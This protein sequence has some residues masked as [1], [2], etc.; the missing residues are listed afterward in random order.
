MFQYIKQ[1]ARHCFPNFYQR[2]HDHKCNCWIRGDD[3]N[4][5]QKLIGNSQ[6]LVET[7]IDQ[8]IP[9][10]PAP[11]LPD[12]FMDGLGR[13]LSGYEILLRSPFSYALMP[14]D[15]VDSSVGLN[16]SL[17]VMLVVSALRIDP[18]V[19]RE[20]RALAEGGYRVHVIAPDISHPPLKEEPID[21]GDRVS[22]EILDSSAADFCMADPYLHGEMMLAA[23]VRYRPLV[24]H[25]HDLSTCL[26]GLAAAR[27]CGSK[28]VCDFH[29][30]FSENVSWSIPQEQW[31]P[32]PQSK[33]DLF[34]AAESLVM[35]QSDEVIT[36]CESIAKELDAKFPWRRR[37]VS[38]IR[39]IPNLSLTPTQDYPSIKE[40]IGV[41]DDAFVV[42]YQGGIGPTRMIEPII[43]A[44]EFSMDTILVVRGPSLDLFGETY[45]KTAV[46]RGVGNR[47]LL[48]PPVPSRDVVIA[49]KGADAGIYTVA[50]LCKNFY[51]AL[52][53]KI[54]EYVGAELPVLAANY[55]E[56]ESL[57]SRYEIGLT[58][59]PVSP[60]SI[61]EVFEK[62][63]DGEVR[64]AFRRNVIAYKEELIATK[65]MDKLV[66]L[67]DG[68]RD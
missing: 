3:T 8:T 26:I 12:N 37:N 62:M 2:L 56:V 27:Y 28:V 65:E 7:S 19:E 60:L 24:F 25:C 32:H 23:A 22:F 53:N 64:G 15:K 58:F 20:A 43:Q 35:R 17:I 51:Y 34:L 40:Q 59:D 10:H 55:P 48:L 18:R 68:L 61:A 5:T 16:D 57:V 47:L 36:V 39:N 49:A 30:W 1:I 41:D 6:E 44:L 45:K 11:T 9:S 66:S 67:Y 13:T 31:V 50:N 14:A 38:V 29:E 63:K 54:F 21:W 42:V 4:V 52:P 33:K 46:E